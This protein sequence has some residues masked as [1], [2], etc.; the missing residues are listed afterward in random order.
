MIPA[1]NPPANP[2]SKLGGALMDS[3]GTI[4]I[5]P[6]LSIIWGKSSICLKEAKEQ[7]MAVQPE[8]KIPENN[9]EAKYHSIMV[10]AL[11]I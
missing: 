4:M 2:D 11:S 3:K 10:R 7:L 1:R 9:K 6:L 5:D 8:S